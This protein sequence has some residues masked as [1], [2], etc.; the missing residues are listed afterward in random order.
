MQV[1]SKQVELEVIQKGNAEEQIKLIDE[2]CVTKCVQ[3]VWKLGA[4]SL[5]I[6]RF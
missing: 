2:V 6:C 4:V 1:K 3:V 5:T